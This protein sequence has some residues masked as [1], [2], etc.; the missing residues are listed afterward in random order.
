MPALPSPQQGPALGAIGRRS[1]AASGSVSAGRTWLVLFTFTAGSEGASGKLC[2]ALSDLEMGLPRSLAAPPPLGPRERSRLC[3][4]LYPNPQGAT[5]CPWASTVFHQERERGCVQLT[6]RA[7]SVRFVT[8][9]VD[10]PVESHGD[11][12]PSFL[13][14]QIRGLPCAA[15][16]L[17]TRGRLVPAGLHRGQESTTHRACQPTDA[18]LPHHPEA[19]QPSG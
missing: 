3:L 15:S 10:C 16:T 5:G 8:R 11:R 4:Q 7:D 2:P 6:L 13:E 1:D 18:V 17:A 19:P 14:D 9:Q 12:G